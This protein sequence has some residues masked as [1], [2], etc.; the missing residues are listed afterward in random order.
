MT[1]PAESCFSGREALP[2]CS[3]KVDEG[4]PRC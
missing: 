3:L 2:E 4:V 1:L